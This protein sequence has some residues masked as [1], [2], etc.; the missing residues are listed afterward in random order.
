MI[1]VDGEPE[2][3]VIQQVQSDHQIQTAAN[4]AA[5]GSLHVLSIGG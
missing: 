1:V 2:Q 3:S 5:D 4:T